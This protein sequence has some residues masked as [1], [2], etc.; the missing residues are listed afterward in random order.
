M[1]FYTKS[2]DRG[3]SKVNNN[4]IPKD[5]LILEVLGELDEL[6]SLIGIVKNLLKKYKK[7]LH[8]IQENLFII[9]AQI[10]WFMYP[11][12]KKPFIE[13]EEI[14]KL[15]KEIDKIEQKMKPQKGFIIPGREINSAWLHYLRAVIRRIERRII[16]FN[17]KYK[18]PT[19]TL[20]YINRLS[21]Y[22]YALARYI[23]FIKKL[24]EENPKYK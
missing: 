10:A 8:Q 18:L 1:I 17:K 3:Y 5:S 12:F 14:K 9:Q 13:E 2:G 19:T 23:V 6:N 16:S 22:I 7:D 11:K 24:K 4:K 20:S 15:E 21:S